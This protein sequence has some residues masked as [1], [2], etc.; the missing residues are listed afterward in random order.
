MK[1]ILLFAALVILLVVAFNQP[2]P[3][4]RYR[5][6]EANIQEVVGPKNVMQVQKNNALFR[7]DSKTGKTWRLVAEQQKTGDHV[8]AWEEVPEISA[9]LAK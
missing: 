2:S 7:L 9:V 3:E 5:L 1:E 6:V 4:G 8:M